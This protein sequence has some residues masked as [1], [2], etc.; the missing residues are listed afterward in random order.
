MVDADGLDGVFV[1][2]DEINDLLD[3]LKVYE[4]PAGAERNHSLGR[5]GN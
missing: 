2:D 1:K 4:P 5:T 3:I